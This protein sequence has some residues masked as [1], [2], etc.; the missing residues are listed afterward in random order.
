M[1]RE[2]VEKKFPFRHAPQVGHF[3]IVKANHESGNEVEFTSQIGQW[4][5]RL[6]APDNA[7]HAQHPCAFAEH[8]KIIE[9]EA[10]DFVSEQLP[11]VS[12]VP[13]AATEIENAFARDNIELD[14]AD[15]ANI[16]VDPTGKI[17]I[18][19]PIFARIVD[20]VA[21]INLFELLTI[22]RID[23]CVRFELDGNAPSEDETTEMASRAAESTAA[24]QFCYFV[25]IAHRLFQDTLQL[26]RDA[27]ISIKMG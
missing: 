22:D 21:L 2:I 24:C 26:W 25:G 13:G 7:S 6:H 15:A 17:E 3:V 16:N 12:E 19:R 23:D 18:F 4:D 1:P 14:V 9:I 8:G 27:A 11:D 10:D 5:E 20:G